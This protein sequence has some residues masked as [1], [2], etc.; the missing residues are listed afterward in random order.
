MAP[1]G[2][3][4]RPTAGS[5][6]SPQKQIPF[7]NSYHPIT[8]QIPIT[9]CEPRRTPSSG[10]A[11]SWRPAHERGA[12]TP[13]AAPSRG[14]RRALGCAREHRL[15]LSVLNELLRKAVRH[16]PR[17][18]LSGLLWIP[19]W[20][21]LDSGHTLSHSP[22]ISPPLARRGYPSPAFGS[23]RPKLTSLRP[24]ATRKRLCDFSATAHGGSSRCSS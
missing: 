21:P 20:I 4:A 8:H 13:R 6:R 10:C 18:F 17:E 14:S 2:V 19:L 11:T 12:R 16:P 23:P 22:V 1:T 3:A 24:P 5:P 9:S 15:S 7:T